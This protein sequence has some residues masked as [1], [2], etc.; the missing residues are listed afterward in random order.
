[1]AQNQQSCLSD[2]VERGNTPLSDISTDNAVLVGSSDIRDASMRF[3]NAY[4]PKA[5]TCS[6]TTQCVG[7]YFRES[8]DVLLIYCSGCFFWCAAAQCAIFQGRCGPCYSRCEN[9]ISKE[10]TAGE[11]LSPSPSFVGVFLSMEN[12]H[13]VVSVD[14]VDEVNLAQVGLLIERSPV[15]YDHINVKVA[16]INGAGETYIWPGSVVLT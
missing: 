16:H 9:T 4:G 7:K 5:L 3:Y 15:F 14:D 11:S 2:T 10:R 13:F 12:S 1:M 6:S 8:T